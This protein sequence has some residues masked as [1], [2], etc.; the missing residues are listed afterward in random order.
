MGERNKIQWCNAG[1]WYIPLYLE[2]N[3]IIILRRIDWFFFGI[4][5][6]YLTNCINWHIFDW[7]FLAN[8]RL[9]FHFQR[10]DV[11]QF[12][13]I[14]TKNYI[15]HSIIFGCPIWNGTWSKQVDQW[16]RNVTNLVW[17]SLFW[18]KNR[19]V[20]IAAETI[21]PNT[22]MNN[23]RKNESKRKRNLSVTRN[24]TS[25]GTKSSFPTFLGIKHTT[26]LLVIINDSIGYPKTIDGIHGKHS[27]KSN[28]NMCNIMR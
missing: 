2:N 23:A 8:S 16:I 22:S 4:Y 26:L 11:D 27:N 3:W 5:Y 6:L 21:D 14:R 12:W 19:K 24:I 28:D 1:T 9:K 13:N 25:F 10:S 18:N 15:F 20:C 17:I 7:S